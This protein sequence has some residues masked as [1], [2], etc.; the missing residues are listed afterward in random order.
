MKKVDLGDEIIG[1]KMDEL[2]RNR[3]YL[4]GK[5]AERL[6]LVR[7]KKIRLSNRGFLTIIR[8]Q[9]LKE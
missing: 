9:I 7:W 1:K 3:F 5:K 2:I 6:F 4:Y 8:K